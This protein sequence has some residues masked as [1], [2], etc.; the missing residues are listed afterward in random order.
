[1]KLPIAVQLWSLRD[2]AE[3]DFEAT[4]ENVAKLGLD[5]VEFAGFYNYSAVDMN[6]LL[7]RTGLKAAS[8]HISCDELKQDVLAVIEYNKTI[9]NKNI[10]IPYIKLENQH[11]LDE[12]VDF[13]LKIAP[14]IR[15]NGMILH[16]HNHDSEFKKIKGRYIL[17]LLIER[18]SSVNLNLELDTYWCFVGGEDPENYLLRN[19]NKINLIHLKDGNG[20]HELKSIGEGKNNI[21]GI[22]KQSIKMKIDWLILE[23]DYPKPSGLADLEKSMINLK[24]MFNFNV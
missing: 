13:I 6:T 20:G 8:A 1:M 11:D 7:K 4:L 21:S 18:C 12:A 10:V 22:L 2:E 23:N 24:N 3:K 19:K 16:Y 17:D 15:D 5:G 14:V 9:G